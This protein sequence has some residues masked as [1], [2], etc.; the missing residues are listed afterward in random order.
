MSLTR[1][2]GGGEKRKPGTRDTHLEPLLVVV[3]ANV[4]VVAVDV[5]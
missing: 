2:S 1:S 3:V 4:V 5:V